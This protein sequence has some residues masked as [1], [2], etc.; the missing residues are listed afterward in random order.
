MT[1]SDGFFIHV[2]TDIVDAFLDECS[3]SLLCYNRNQIPALPPCKGL[4]SRP[5][6]AM[7]TLRHLFATV[8]L[9]SLL[10]GGCGERH[11]A[12]SRVSPDLPV[13]KVAVFA[14]GRLT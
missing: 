7:R 9:L 14:D 8:G 5:L 2:Q 6:D 4:R 10:C 12:Q 13:L 3:V 11:A 1:A